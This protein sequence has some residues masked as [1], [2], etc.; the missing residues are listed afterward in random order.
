MK[1]ASVWETE[2]QR[3]LSSRRAS[4]RRRSET[5][6]RPEEGPAGGEPLGTAAF[7]AVVTCGARVRPRAFPLSV[8]EENSAEI[9]QA[10]PHGK[11]LNEHEFNNIFTEA[12]KK[13]PRGKSIKLN[14]LKECMRGV[15]F[16]RFKFP[17][18][19]CF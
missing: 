8:Q 12:L 16:W 6:Q 13:H 2:L 9:L 7:A 11:R 19:L 18:Y 3:R 17:K 14:C 10:Q 4:R 15:S 1:S 5:R